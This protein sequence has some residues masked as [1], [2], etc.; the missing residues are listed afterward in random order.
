[1]AI[2]DWEEM[3]AQLTKHI[4]NKDVLI[5]VLLVGITWLVSDWSGKGKLCNAVKSVSRYPHLW[6]SLRINIGSRWRWLRLYFIICLLRWPLLRTLGLNEFSVKLRWLRRT[7]ITMSSAL[8]L[9]LLSLISLLLIAFSRAHEG[10]RRC[11][12]AL[13]K[14]LLSSFFVPVDVYIDSRLLL[15]GIQRRRCCWTL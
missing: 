8:N 2:A 6:S 15:L 9:L 12:C 4:G 3:E 14:L 11:I 5:L 1:M 10:L 13:S 7:W